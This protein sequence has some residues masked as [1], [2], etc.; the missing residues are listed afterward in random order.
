M[1]KNGSVKHLMEQAEFFEDSKGNLYKTI[2]TVIDMTELHQYQEELRQLSSH[3][4]KAQEEE[5]AHIAREIHDELG[6]R[7]TGMIR[8]ARKNKVGL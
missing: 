7:L 2:G 5:R 3:I 4:Q 6:Q 8:V 1:L